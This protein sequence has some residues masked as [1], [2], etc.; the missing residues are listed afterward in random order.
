MRSRRTAAVILSVALVGSA[1]GDAD[2]VI[3]DLE[4]VFADAR[5]LS[6][7][8]DP[9]VQA[10]S[11]AWKATVATQDAEDALERS[12]AENDLQAAHD[13]TALRPDDPR[14]PIY[15]ELMTS[16]ATLSQICVNKGA[17]EDWLCEERTVEDRK[18]ELTAQALDLI[19]A[20]H[21]HDEDWS[22]TTTKRVLMEMQ[23][24]ALRHAIEANPTSPL[25][26]EWLLVYCKGIEGDYNRLH[27]TEFVEATTNYLA[28]NVGAAGFA[29]CN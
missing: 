29:H 15:E 6:G 23:L 13:A 1:C 22:D 19:D 28:L 4:E 25:Q 24:D 20:Q 14:Y 12:I 17:S 7:S 21:E 3:D 11:E 9:A 8:D 5:N 2:F 16:E 26:E 18:E 27:G 10:S